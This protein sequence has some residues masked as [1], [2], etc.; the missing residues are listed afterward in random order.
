M[1]LELSNDRR[2]VIKMLENFLNDA[3]VIQLRTKEWLSSSLLYINPIFDPLLSDLIDPFEVLSGGIPLSYYD[4]M[5]PDS[6]S[7]A[8]I[9]NTFKILL[10]VLRVGGIS[11]FNELENT[12]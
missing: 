11:L 4:N 9:L 7:S 3:P 2:I 1:L 10:S 8:N 5:G 12:K 6:T